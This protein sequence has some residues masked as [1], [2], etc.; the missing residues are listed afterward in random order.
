M[1]LVNINNIFRDF[2]LTTQTLTQIEIERNNGTWENWTNK[3]ISNWIQTIL[4]ER[5]DSNDQLVVGDIDQFMN[6]FNNLRIN[7]ECIKKLI[8]NRQ[9]LEKFK[10]K[11][12]NI[13]INCQTDWEFTIWPIFESALNVLKNKMLNDDKNDVVII[14]QVET[15]FDEKENEKENVDNEQDHGTKQL[16]HM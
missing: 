12:D 10:H 7:V 13:I 5:F 6:K 16:Q 14:K 8:E 2:K 15:T 9:F 3:D 11:F 1:K 4:N